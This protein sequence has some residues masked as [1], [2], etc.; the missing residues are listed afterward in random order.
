[1]F[2]LRREERTYDGHLATFSRHVI[3]VPEALSHG[4]VDCEATPEEDTHFAV[5]T[6]LGVRSRSGG[7]KLG[8]YLEL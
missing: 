8:A 5:L 2:R 1:M 3:L 6:W 7:L 4:V